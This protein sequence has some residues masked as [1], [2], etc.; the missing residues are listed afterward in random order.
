MLLG[1]LVSVSPVKALRGTLSL[2]GD[3]SIS[4]RSAIIA[5]LA[6]KGTS[7]I[8]NFSTSEDC[9]STLRCL[10]Q[11]G[12]KVMREAAATVCIEGAGAKG[13]RAPSEPLNCGNSGST[14]RMLA[15]A[16]AGHD[17]VATLTGDE[18]LL[19]R[20]MKRIIQPLNQT[21]AH[22]QGTMDRAPLT[23]LGR[24][25]LSAIRYELP[26]ASAQVK[27]AIL[28]AGL[29]AR[30]RTEI[31]EP[32]ATR[33][34]TERLLSWFSIKVDSKTIDDDGTSKT[35]TALEASQPFAARDVAVPGDMSS[36][37]FLI[38]AAAAFPE[39][40]LLITDVGLNPTRTGFL[41]ILQ[42]LGGDIELRNVRNEF[43]EPIGDVYFRGRYKFEPQAPRA[44]LIRG[45]LVAQVIDELPILAVLGTRLLGGIEIRD[46]RELRVK[47]SDRLAATVTNLRVMGAEVEEFEDGLKVRGPC[48]LQGAVLD[49]YGDHRIAMAFSVAALIATGT[50]EIKGADCVRVSFPEFFRSLESVSER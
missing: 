41:S 21:G 5:A 22:I 27:T 34:H 37:A 40:E 25:P 20:P 32:N 33:D 17:V 16:L 12:V 43:N 8:T 23:V 4:H 38:A 50:S 2:P 14:M 7:R 13:F 35:R 31:I 18:S 28:L 30:G 42:L 11:L 29:N 10:E 46:A 19:T 45:S 47:E 39:S 1:S 48:Q 49:S 44:N 26:V 15:G 3:K 36:A 9:E 6:Y 24:Q